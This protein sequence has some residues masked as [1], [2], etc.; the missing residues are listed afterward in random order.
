M[1]DYILIDLLDEFERSVDALSGYY[2]EY[3]PYRMKR[4]ELTRQA[5][6]DYVEKLE[7]QISEYQ[8]ETHHNH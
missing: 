5:I 4:V 3:K 7:Q 6:L 8:S 1:R 2:G